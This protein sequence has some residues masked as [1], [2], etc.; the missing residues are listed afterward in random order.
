MMTSRM[1]RHSLSAFAL[2][3]GATLTSGNAPAQT[4]FGDLV[5]QGSFCVGLDCPNSPNFG[6]DTIILRENNLR[7]FFDDTSVGSFPKNKWRLTLNSDASGGASFFAIDDVT[8]TKQP[9]RIS[10]GARGNSIFVDPTGN[11]GFGTATPGLTTHARSGNTPSHRLEQD[12]SA[13]WPAQTWDIGANEANFFVRDLTNGSKLPFRIRPG[14][15]TSS[16]DISASGKVGVG[17]ASPSH[18]LSLQ[19]ST[20]APQ[21]RLVGGTGG[22]YLMA[23]QSLP[24]TAWFASGTEWNGANWIGRASKASLFTLTGGGLTLHGVS[25]TSDGAMINFGTAK[26][27]VDG[28]TG[29][30]GVGIAAPSSR[31][32]TTGTVRFEGVAGCGGGIQSAANG[33]LSCIMSTRQVKNIVGELPSSVALANIMALRPQMGSYKQT[34]DVPEHWLIAEDVAAVDP[35]LAGLHEGK[36]HVIKTQNVVADLVAV[37][38]QQQQQIEELR[39]LVAAK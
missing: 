20:F 14:A 37:V 36:P 18:L 26:L 12:T 27:V 10:A 24:D 23:D 11:V 31:L 13:G 3:I 30:V 19:Q 1:L 7:I 29:N 32:H 4:V 22:G 2:V 28:T 39:R 35:A 38:Q 33:T 34:P 6:F 21:V 9:F 8:A 15:P 16:L 5:A 17:T 25:S